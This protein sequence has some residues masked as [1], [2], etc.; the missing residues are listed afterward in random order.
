MGSRAS[1]CERFIAEFNEDA[2]SRFDLS[3]LPAF[4]SQSLRMQGSSE[5]VFMYYT[6]SWR[7]HDEELMQDMIVYDPGASNDDTVE[8]VCGLLGLEE[9]EAVRRL[10]KAKVI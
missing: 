2:K 3:D 7:G 6:F 4:W 9:D 1:K 10:R 8:M 5:M